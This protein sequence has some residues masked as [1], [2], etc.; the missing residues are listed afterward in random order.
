MYKKRLVTQDTYYVGASE[1]RLALFENVYPLNNGVSYNSY[2]ILDEKTCLLDSVDKS[3]ED[4]F[5][6]KV[7][8]GL[9]GR[10]L[11]Y[12]VVDH[13]EPDHAYTLKRVIDLYPEVNVVLN[14]KT[15]RMF[16]NFNNGF[17]PKNFTI[18][19]EMDQLVL[20]KH[21]LVFIFAPM[22]HWPEVMVTYDAYT[23]TLFSADAF[24]TF[25]ALN[26][27]LFAHE[28][29]F[30]HEYLDES[31]RYYTN[32]V[33]KYGTQVQAI[34]K[35]ASTVEIETICPLHGPIWRQDINYLI[36][37]YD[38]WSRYEPEVNGVLIVY[39]SIYGNTE[40]VANLIADSLA[41]EGIKNIK[42]YDVSKTDKS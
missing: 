1:R 38:K 17:E 10:K 42:M 32:I 34:L 35:K 19:K 13:M 36:S 4:V 41:L 37:L 9:N 28:V 40:E 33:G 22:V 18:V 20:G 6:K 5:I 12:L 27:N 26:G 2:L 14:D 31:R 8:D 30:E 15:L 21:T 24:G 16:K 11:D 23:K 7:V 39:G 29:N 25:A 3:V